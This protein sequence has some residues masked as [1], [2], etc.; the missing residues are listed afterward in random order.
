M[1]GIK[2]KPAWQ[3][4][5]SGHTSE[6]DPVFPSLLFQIDGHLLEKTKILEK[7]ENI[8]ETLRGPFIGL[9]IRV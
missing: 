4:H 3:T 5:A 2:R 1:A 9:K 8:Y 6:P 7:T